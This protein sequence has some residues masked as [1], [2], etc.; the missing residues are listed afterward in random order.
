MQMM[1]MFG[2][3]RERSYAEFETVLA[4]G[5]FEAL[6]AIRTASPVSIVEARPR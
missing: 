2:A 5:G 6:R 4:A 1:A 3:A